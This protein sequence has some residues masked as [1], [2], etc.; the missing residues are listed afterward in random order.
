MFPIT[1]CAWF[2]DAS[3]GCRKKKAQAQSLQV[4]HNLTDRVGGEKEAA[5]FS[6][7]L[8]KWGQASR[9]EEAKSCA[10]QVHAS[11]DWVG[12]EEESPLILQL[13]CAVPLGFSDPLKLIFTAPAQMEVIATAGK[14]TTITADFISRCSLKGNQRWCSPSCL[15]V[16]RPSAEP[17]SN[18][19]RESTT[20][21]GSK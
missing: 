15:H 21:T 5:A 3:Q 19:H 7:T 8:A 17:V 9:N 20:A 16:D 10:R 12:T 14:E 2:T 13:G 11:P 6:S 1:W 18:T 4:L